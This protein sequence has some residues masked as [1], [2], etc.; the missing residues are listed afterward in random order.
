MK[1]RSATKREENATPRVV[2]DDE[3]AG[4]N[5]TYVRI[6]TDGRAHEVD[7]AHGRIKE[8]LAAGEIVEVQ[9]RKADAPKSA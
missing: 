2:L 5:G 3:T 7:A 1:V 4:V 9:E 8:L 6:I